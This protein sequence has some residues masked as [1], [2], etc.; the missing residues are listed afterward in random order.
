[1]YYKIICFLKQQICRYLPYF[2]RTAL[3]EFEKKFPLHFWIP[4]N[5]DLSPEYVGTKTFFSGKGDEGKF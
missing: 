1:M 5:L 3:G 2:K 4:E